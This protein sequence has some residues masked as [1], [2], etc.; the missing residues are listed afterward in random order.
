MSEI[1][2][3]VMALLLAGFVATRISFL[4]RIP[5]SVF[6]VVLGVAAG[7]VLHNH[8][9]ISPNLPR[10]LH[11]IFPELVFFVLLPPLVFD[12]SFHL[13]LGWLKK[14]LTALATLAIISLLLSTILIGWGLHH[15]FDLDLIACLTFG[16]LISATDPV[17]VV[18]LFKEVGAPLRLTTLVEGESLLNDGTAIVLFR[19]LIAA[20]VAV[21]LSPSV[22]GWSIVQFFLVAG[23]AVL[24]GIVVTVAVVM[25]L[26]F[27]SQSSAAQL[28]I[29]VCAAFL[30]FILADHFLHVSGVIAT[31]VVGLGVGRHA[32]R[33]FS[34][35]SLEG[36]QHVWDFL[37]LAAN[38]LVFFTVGLSVDPHLLRISLNYIPLTLLIV[39]LARAF[40]IFTVIPVVNRVRKKEPISF[41]YQVVLFWGGIRGGLALGLVL[42]LPESFAHRELFIALALSVVFSTLFVNALTTGRV[43][44]LVKLKK[45]S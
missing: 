36:M 20:S 11:K 17:A 23:G 32:R 39:Y 42:M 4:L 34:K 9:A 30:S 15:V 12:S 8:P 33:E 5:H 10:L 22:W 16:A 18:A 41:A 21:E 6:L 19:T 25:L 31:M 7:L 14:D 37:G 38:T 43:M 1:V 40:S 3:I 35:A 26:K 24:V 29:T 2:F 44:G 13:D 27:A 45:Q 28:G